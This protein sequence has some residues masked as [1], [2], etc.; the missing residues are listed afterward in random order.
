MAKLS[1]TY[2]IGQAVADGL[3]SD[4]SDCTR[5]ARLPYPVY[6]SS[7]FFNS[8]EIKG[9]KRRVEGVV[10]MAYGIREDIN[11]KNF[12]TYVY[13]Q[14]SHPEKGA[15]GVSY[16]ATLMPCETFGVA[17]FITEREGETLDLIMPR[18]GGSFYVV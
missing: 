10:E 1:D 7:G 3:L 2:S 8:F 9:S 15:W 13:N 18:T 5:D 17:N 6:V 12:G 4:V 14:C 11:K 16:R